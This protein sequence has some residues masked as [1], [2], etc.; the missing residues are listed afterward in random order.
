MSTILG[1]NCF[2]AD[3]AACLLD[4]QG[5]LFATAEERLNRSKHYAGFPQVAIE[6]VLDNA[7]LR[8]SD[9]DVVVVARDGRANL[10]SKLAFAL[11]NARRLPRLARQRL[12]NRSDVA[13]VPDLIRQRVSGGDQ[14]RFE[15]FRVEHH[16]AH[17]ASAF[18]ASEYQEAAL[19]SIDGF[20]DFASAMRGVGN[21]TSLNVFDRALFPHSMGV[22]YTALCQFIGYD[23]YG[24]EGKVM[25][26]APYGEDRYADL[27]NEVVQVGPEGQFALNLSYFQHHTL[28]VDYTFDEE[29]RPTVGRLYTDRLIERLGAPRLHGSEITQ[30]DMDIARSMQACLE[31]VYLSLVNDLHRRTGSKNLC[32]A[33]GVA[34]NSVANGMVLDHSPFENVYVQPAAGDDGTALGAALW[35]R[36]VVEG[37]PRG[38]ALDH[39]YLGRE[40]SAAQIQGAVDACAADL[41][42]EDLS[43]PE[44]YA[45]TARVIAEG[46]VVGWFQGRSEWGPRALGNRSILAHPGYPGMKDTLNAR[47]KHREWFRPFAPSILEER[48][49]DCFQATH[50]SPFMLMVYKTRPEWYE[51][52]SAVDH[53]DHTGRVQT[54]TRKANQRYY[55]LIKAFDTLTGIPVLLNTSFNENEPVVDRPEEA[56]DCFLRTKMDVLV[57]GNIMLRKRASSL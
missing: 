42:R 19:F 49:S 17:L 2:H 14:A 43:E 28:G 21:G 35:Y 38:P 29:G 3:A 15:T 36:H 9:I 41:I 4:S 30:R 22:F 7:S 11:R 46:N 55:D 18:F 48:L 47:I 57:M 12:R 53:V 8:I 34:L 24:D 13:S 1:L 20:G 44:L 37:A 31:R 16:L 26:L 5:N 56:L 39:A 23:H 32:I 10:R 40:W 54:V 51:R 45:K 25:G 50:P 52:L 6:A 27:M 33:G